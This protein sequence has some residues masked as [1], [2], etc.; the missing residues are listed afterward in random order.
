MHAIPSLLGQKAIYIP[1]P[2]VA[3]RQDL[4]VDVLPPDLATTPTLAAFRDIPWTEG[5]VRPGAR[6]Q[7]EPDRNVITDPTMPA[8]AALARIPWNGAALAAPTITQSG[9]SVRSIFDTFK[10]E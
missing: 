4:Q 1:A 7:E 9:R 6:K 2:R 5:P 8:G 10:W 3:S